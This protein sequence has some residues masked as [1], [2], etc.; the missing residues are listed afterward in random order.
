[1]PT[2]NAGQEP[3]LTVRSLRIPLPQGGDRSHALYDLSLE[4]ERGEVLCVVGESGSGKSMLANALIRLLPETVRIE[5]GDI[6]FAG[7][8]LLALDERGMRQLRGNRIAMVFQDQIG[9]ATCRERE[10]ITVAAGTV[11]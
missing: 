3:L 2:D 7:Q 10:D 4:L 6:R 8:D 9:R 1:M 11:T 5:Q